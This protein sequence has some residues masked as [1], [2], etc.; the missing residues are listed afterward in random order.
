MYKIRVTYFSGKISIIKFEF[1]NYLIAYKWLR[2]YKKKNG[3]K[4]VI[5][6]KNFKA[7]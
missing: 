6:F 7:V 1:N 3:V 2:A 5:I 4:E